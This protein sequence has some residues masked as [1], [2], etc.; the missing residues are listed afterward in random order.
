[1]DLGQ[2]GLDR[3]TE[4]QSGRCDI[5]RAV[6]GPD[7]CGGEAG[8]SN[9]VRLNARH[10]VLSVLFCTWIVSHMDRM[11]IAVALPY[12]SD[13]FDLTPLQ[14]GAL[15]SAFFAG[16]A[17]MH[18]PGGFLADRFGVRRVATIAMLWWSAF[19]ALTGAAMNFVQMVVIRFVFGLGEGVFPACA[20]KTIAVWFPRKERATANALMLASNPLGIAISPLIVV[21]I[22]GLWDWRA[23]F[24]VLLAPGVIVAVLFW[25]SVFN[26]PS[27]S[28]RISREEV[29]HI[30]DGDADVS[31]DQDHVSI[32]SLFRDIQM[33]LFFLSY[34]T[35][36]VAIWGF[37]V[38]LP[39]YLVKARGLS[40]AEMGVA[41]SLPF[42]VG[43]LGCALGG[44]VSDRFFSSHRKT[45]IIAA[46]LLAAGALYMAA[47]SKSMAV[48]LVCQCGVGFF[49]MF[50]VSA[51]W[52]LP[53]NTVP[54]RFM[55]VA[56]G[57][58]NMGGQLAGMMSPLAIGYLVGAANG[59]YEVALLFMVGSLVLCALL[60][61]VTPQRRSGAVS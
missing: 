19:T 29:A 45:P 53:M 26:H 49:L 40:M 28:K 11:A 54:K 35:Y 20:F 44:W 33:L 3:E 61:A 10:S 56:A 32:W 9:L 42:L 2:H 59:N 4:A 58:I 52:A 57:F 51:F 21:A 6:V 34:F 47:I 41:S 12:M 43:T 5:A 18:I 16:Y 27:E 24:F 55:G 48:A 39:T 23:V 60:V 22:M 17:L 15:M 46:L 7:R 25:R 31:S 1:M 8:I 50:F 14:S 38:W 36:A 30:A 37:T 13:D